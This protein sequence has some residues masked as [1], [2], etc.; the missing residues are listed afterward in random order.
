M[1]GTGQEK[2]SLTAAAEV[3][4][5]E[6]KDK[7]WKKEPRGAALLDGGPLSRPAEGPPASPPST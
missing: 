5:E 3:L 1:R 2:E 6:F 7:R 4:E